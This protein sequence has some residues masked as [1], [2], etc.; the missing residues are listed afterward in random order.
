[1]VPIYPELPGLTFSPFIK[2]PKY[3]TGVGV[4]S[5]GREVRI[6]YWANPQWEWD[7]K[8][9][10]L[11][12]NQSVWNY[13]G[14]TASDLKTLLGFVLSRYG[15]QA[16]FYF[17]DPDDCAVTNQEIGVGDGGTKQFVFYRT[18]GLTETGTEPIGGLNMSEDISIY[19][20]GVLQTSGFTIDNSIPCG[21]FVMFDTAPGAGVSVTASFQFYF[22]CRFKDD[23]TDFEK[24]MK[25]LWENQKIT[26]FSL[27]N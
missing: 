10:T 14:G 13:Q 22:Y 8:Y 18:Y 3:S 16:P 5:S 4:G 7:L 2:R 26:I 23:S 19:L 17:R 24:F 6:G 12:D 9:D 27:K 20:N 15:A 1:M 11:G 21:N 25:Q